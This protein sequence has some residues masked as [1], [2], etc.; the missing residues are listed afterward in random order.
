[1]IID[2]LIQKRLRNRIAS[3]T[4]RRKRSRIRS[5]LSRAVE[6]L[7]QQDGSFIETDFLRN[8]DMTQ[9][10]QRTLDLFEHPVKR[11]MKEDPRS[12][13]AQRYRDRQEQRLVNLYAEYTQLKEYA[14]HSNDFIFV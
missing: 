6:Q 13:N 12:L 9:L 8:L 3:Q 1:M 4:S 10:I 7:K 14:K 5:E 2:T 11:K